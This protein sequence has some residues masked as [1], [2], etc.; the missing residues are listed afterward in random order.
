MSYFAPDTTI[1][2]LKNVPL[3]N[4][5]EHSIYFATPQNQYDYFYSLRKYKLDAQSYQ[6]VKRGWMRVQIKADNLYDCNYLAFQN[7]SFGTKWFYAFITSVEYVNDVLSPSLS[8]IFFSCLL[9]L[10]VNLFALF[11]NV[12]P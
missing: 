5:Y 4:S 7:T 3:D 1:I 9:T 10:I 6:R 8:S 12:K 2:F 11:N